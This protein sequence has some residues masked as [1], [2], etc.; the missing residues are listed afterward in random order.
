M[1]E[2]KDQPL[3]AGRPVSRRTVVLA[4]SAGAVTGGIPAFAQEP[5]VRRANKRDVGVLASARDL[6]GHRAADKTVIGLFIEARA[7][8][9][10]ESTNLVQT[11]G[12]SAPGRGHASY[13]YESTVDA[14]YIADHPETSFLSANGRGFNL[15][16]NES[17]QP[18]FFGAAGD[19]LTDDL[20][21][22]NA[23]LAAA[24]ALGREVRLDPIKSYVLK[25][26]SAVGKLRIPSGIV[27]N[28]NNATLK[29][30]NGFFTRGVLIDGAQN[31]TLRNLRIEL[32]DTT[33]GV[34]Y[35]GIAVQN[36]SDVLCENVTV[37]DP[38]FDQTRDRATRATIDY[39][40]VVCQS[41]ASSQPD[42]TYAANGTDD[43]PCNEVR[44]VNCTADGCW[45]LGFE[46]FPKVA[47]HGG[48]MENC[49]ARNCGNPQAA[50]IIGSD[51][52][53]GFKFG[54]VDIDFQSINCTADTCWHGGILANWSVTHV[55]NF[56]IIDYRQNGLL[57]GNNDHPYFS[58]T[59]GGN[60]GTG[61]AL[62][63]GVMPYTRQVANID[64]LK[65]T[66]RTGF[67]PNNTG[68]QAAIYWGGG[69]IAN[70]GTVRIENFDLDL[71]GNHEGIDIDP[72]AN[73]SG[74]EFANGTI[75]CNG[76]PFISR[77]G[78]G[79]MLSGPV[80]DSITYVNKSKRSAFRYFYVWARNA[81]IRDMRLI[82][83]STYGLRLNGGGANIDG[84]MIANPSSSF[85]PIQIDDNTPVT[86][87]LSGKV[88]VIGGSV[89]RLAQCRSKRPRIRYAAGFTLVWANGNA[90]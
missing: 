79:G 27:V 29:M 65:I 58:A 8:D 32:A 44:F 37:I 5:R 80:I 75:R 74:I 69:A 61:N 89:S 71:G 20:D 51:A 33:A 82:G 78:L 35:Y 55:K 21:A 57:I 14:A 39:G 66:H 60:G 81:V 64:G 25:R 26:G 48:R 50:S 38:T 49:I 77:T 40:F 12:Y 13:S 3:V 54:Q 11:S 36:S 52:G 87:T 67:V 10:P 4:I 45:V 31:V 16:E 68:T 42:G 59:T 43:L 70:S 23:T 53:A 34:G 18:E 7:F 17:L 22:I 30:A 90:T 28:G 2:G 84:L 85:I 83:P 62:A 47:S 24:V 6:K 41:T 88:T 9:I 19:G 86:Y 15:A 46:Y 72:A 56:T 76:L 1:C 63:N 73:I